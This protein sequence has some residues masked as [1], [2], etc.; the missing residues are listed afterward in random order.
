[1]AASEEVLVVL[2]AGPLIHLDELDCLH[3]LEGFRLLLIPTRV[4]SEATHH[5]PSL[6]LDKIAGAKIVDPLGLPPPRMMQ[7]AHEIELHDGELAALT[8]IHEAGGGLLLSDDDA[9]RQTA[10]ALGFAVSGTL[11]LILRGVRREVLTRADALRLIA[12][13][14]KRST[15]HASRRLLERI[16]AALPA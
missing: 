3:L 11:G 2:D 7:T 16:A 12:D 10:V 4:W 15:L 13:I 5:R 9:A 14:P 6:R 8:L 1:M